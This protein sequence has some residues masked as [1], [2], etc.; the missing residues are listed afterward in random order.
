[1]DIQF[2]CDQCG[3]SIVIDE[4]GAGL[5][6]DCPKCGQS[7]IIPQAQPHPPEPSTDIPPV[8]TK[9]P[10]V[11]AQATPTFRCK[12]GEP[13]VVNEDGTEIPYWCP[14]C[15]RAFGRRKLLRGH[16][17]HNKSQVAQAKTEAGAAHAEWLAKDGSMFG[18][19]A[20]KGSAVPT[21]P[22]SSFS[23]TVSASDSDTQIIRKIRRGV[24]RQ[25]NF[26]GASEL[27]V[28][29][30]RG[31][32]GEFEL[33]VKG[34]DDLVEMAR[35]ILGLP[36][37]ASTPIPDPIQE[38]I[39]QEDE[40]E[41]ELIEPATEKQKAYLMDLG[42]RFD[43]A[44]L[45][46]EEASKLIT[47]AQSKKPVTPRQIEKLRRLGLPDVPEEYDSAQDAS[48]VLESALL[49]APTEVQLA[50]AKELGFTIP[51][52]AQFDAGALDDI[53]KLADRQPDTE[54]LTALR[55]D[56]IGLW[57]GTALEGRML[58]EL[59]EAYST[60]RWEDDLPRTAL[61]A[62][63]AVA[64]RD[65]AFYRVT[66]DNKTLGLQPFHWA[67]TKLKEWVKGTGNL[68]EAW[69]K[70][71]QLQPQNGHALVKLGDEY[72]HAGRLTDAITT[73]KQAITLD[74]NWD[75]PW[76]ALAALYHN[77][78]QFTEAESAFVEAQRAS[79]KG[80]S[81]F[82]RALK[83]GPKYIELQQRY[84]KVFKE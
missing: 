48:E 84:P 52:D 78:G 26:P 34:P 42:V 21:I 61:G 43:A 83:R 65:P 75:D 22:A 53:L 36:V 81:G 58:F 39:A 23:Q 20:G 82:V 71:V 56:G 46:K 25:L 60:D 73:Y 59:V 74:P 47:D 51:E 13:I 80:F 11:I 15:H 32:N 40:G 4:A 5:Q 77:S 41:A 50:R 54:T 12:C 30:I 1:M 9:L 16:A 64:V 79:P 24:L 44:R 66:V 10:P 55:A 18:F 7:L 2:D 68:I 3:Q 6:V 33:S 27:K 14:K 17:V 76:I 69:E 45:S 72:K 35:T 37:G 49:G 31:A 8:I 29:V 63:C 70:E 57:K 28:R 19:G 38:P 67:E 62:V